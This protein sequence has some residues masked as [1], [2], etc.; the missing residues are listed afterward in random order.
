VVPAAAKAAGYTFKHPEL[1]A[2]LAASLD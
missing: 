2:A 1:P